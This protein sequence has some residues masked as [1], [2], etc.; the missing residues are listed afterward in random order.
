MIT[1][2]CVLIPWADLELDIRNNEVNRYSYKASQ[3]LKA[4]P[5]IPYLIFMTVNF[6]YMTDNEQCEHSANIATE[7]HG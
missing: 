1:C 3:G 2:V 7:P 4:L 5:D 6:Y